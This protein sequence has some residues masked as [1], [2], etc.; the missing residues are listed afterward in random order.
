VTAPAH[1]TPGLVPERL[2]Q[3]EYPTLRALLDDVLVLGVWVQ[4]QSLRWLPF[5]PANEAVELMW[6]ERHLTD[7][8]RAA[9][10]ARKKVEWRRRAAEAER[11]RMDAASLEDACLSP[12]EDFTWSAVPSAS[13]TGRLSTP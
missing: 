8:E 11:D 3:E 7:L 9:G 6:L 1:S 13:A 2:P 5:P 4:R 12:P 10:V